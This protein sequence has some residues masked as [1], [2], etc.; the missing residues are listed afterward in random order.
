[1]MESFKLEKFRGSFQKAK[2]KIGRNIQQ[3]ACNRPSS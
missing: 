2:E 1:M 3:L